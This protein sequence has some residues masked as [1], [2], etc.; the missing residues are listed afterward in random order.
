MAC[1]QDSGP[2]IAAF[3]SNRGTDRQCHIPS[4]SAPGHD[5]RGLDEACL[6]EDRLRLDRLPATAFRNFLPLSAM[7]SFLAEQQSFS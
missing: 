1:G 2:V 6:I 5:L 3:G 4:I 7:R